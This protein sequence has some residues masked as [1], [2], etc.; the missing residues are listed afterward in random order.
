[1][2]LFGVLLGTLYYWNSVQRKILE[3]RRDETKKEYEKLYV[4]FKQWADPYQ[5]LLDASTFDTKDVIWLDTLRDIAPHFPDQKDMIVTQMDYISGPI[6]GIANGTYFSGRINISAMAREWS[7]VQTLKQNLEAKGTYF[8]FPVTPTLNP[9]GGGY[10]W[11][12]KITIGCYKIS[13]PNFYLYY[14][15]E[16]QKVESAKNPEMYQKGEE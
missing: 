14:L 9:A 13:D 5:M 2:L 12:Y 1:V 11:I 3:G 4:T 10:P 15:S 8:V 6:S 16:E 7:V